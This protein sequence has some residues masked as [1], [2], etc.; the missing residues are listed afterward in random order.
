GPLVWP[1]RIKGP[2]KSLRPRAKP[3]APLPLLT[4]CLTERCGPHQGLPRIRPP[5][6]MCLMG[7]VDLEII[8]ETGFKILSRT[9]VGSLQKPAGEDAKPQLD[10]VEPGAVCGRKVEDMRMAWITQ[11]G[12]ALYPMAQVLGHKGHLA[13]LRHHTADVQAPVGVEIIHYP[14]VTLHV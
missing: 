14:V 7:V 2:R 10:L 1:G 4:T 5:I 13:P 6:W 11:E 12:P 8:R 3:R 9:E